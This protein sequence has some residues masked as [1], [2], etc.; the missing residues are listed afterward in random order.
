[1][2]LVRKAPKMIEYFS[3]HC[4][5]RR[6]SV[7]CIQYV[8]LLM[9][10]IRKQCYSLK[11]NKCWEIIYCGLIL[12][13]AKYKRVLVYTFVHFQVKMFI[14]V[15]F[16]LKSWLQHVIMLSLTVIYVLSF[17]KQRWRYG[18]SHVAS[19]V[20]HSI[21]FSSHKNSCLPNPC[22]QALSLLD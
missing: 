1:M 22:H 20:W 8:S 6:G 11:L 15:A 16:L 10:M 13:L 18:F 7:L 9:V 21:L 3:A 12:D 4:H 2:F 17:S 19:S 14:P 5:S